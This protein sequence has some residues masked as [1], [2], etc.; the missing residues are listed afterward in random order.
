LSS[1]TNLYLDRAGH[2]IQLMPA[3]N[4]AQFHALADGA[5]WLLHLA[6]DSMI[7]EI[8][9]NYGLRGN[10]LDTLTQYNPDMAEV[11]RIQQLLNDNQSWLARLEQ[12]YLSHDLEA[13]PAANIIGSTRTQFEPDQE[14]FK[15]CHQQLTELTEQFRQ[16]S[17][18][19]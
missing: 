1:K 4:S 3:Q 17:Q 15:D 11:Q 7:A 8:A 6:F 9:S 16:D 10:D 12:L 19:W 14:F 18:F 13:K 2:L 5:V